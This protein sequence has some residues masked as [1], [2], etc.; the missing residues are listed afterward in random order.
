MFRLKALSLTMA[1]SERRSATLKMETNAR[2]LQAHVPLV[3]QKFW[4]ILWNF[5]TCLPIQPQPYFYLLVT[6]TTCAD[7]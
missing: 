1:L 2:K 6:H 4:K 7:N 5:W 3:E